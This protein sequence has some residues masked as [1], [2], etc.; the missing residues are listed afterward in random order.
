MLLLSLFLS[1]YSDAK[2]LEREKP[3]SQDQSSL[4]SPRNEPRVSVFPIN[5]IIFFA[6]VVDDDVSKRVLPS[7]IISNLA[8][9]MHNKEMI[10]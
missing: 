3:S 8:G 9:G 10:H 1:H 2:S 6:V 7:D 5:C 4:P